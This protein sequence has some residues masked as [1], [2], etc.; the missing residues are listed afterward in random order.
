MGGGETTHTSVVPIIKAN[1][2]P[3]THYG[4]IRSCTCSCGSW[5][6]MT[7]LSG[8]TV[9]MHSAATWNRRGLVH[10]EY[11]SGMHACNPHASN[12]LS[13]MRV[14]ENGC[15]HSF[16]Y[17]QKTDVVSEKSLPPFDPWAVALCNIGRFAQKLVTA[18]NDTVSVPFAMAMFAFSRSEVL[19][20]V[21]LA[22]AL[23]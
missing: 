4:M 16:V 8:V 23:R 20:Y 6:R 3:S 17:V 15:M 11:E 21:S 13:L 18:H 5:P 9:L 7:L 2:G 22:Q 19:S 14:W 12:T 10:D 1:T